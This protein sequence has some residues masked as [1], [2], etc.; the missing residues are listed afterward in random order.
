MNLGNSLSKALWLS[1]GLR[2]TLDEITPNI[3]FEF[4]TASIDDEIT[5]HY[6]IS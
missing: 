1:Y 5:C 3:L 2:I 4:A 6:F